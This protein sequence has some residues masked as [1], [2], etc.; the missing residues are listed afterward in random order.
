MK[1]KNKRINKSEL[2]SECQRIRKD[3]NKWSKEYR[4]YLLEM[5]KKIINGECHEFYIGSLP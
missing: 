2:Q 3:A 1:T 5:G 4:V